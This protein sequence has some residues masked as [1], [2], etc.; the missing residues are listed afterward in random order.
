MQFYSI[1]VDIT[2]W[3]KFSLFYKK[4]PN[5]IPKKKIEKILKTYI[6]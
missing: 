4:I 5:K 1:T 2:V 6:I 3:R